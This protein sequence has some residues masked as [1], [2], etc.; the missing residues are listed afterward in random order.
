MKTRILCL[1]EILWNRTDEKHPLSTKQLSDIL[2][3]DYDFP[4][5]HRNTI[6][7]DMVAI[8][9]FGIDV[10]KISSTQNKYYI[11]NRLF[12]L[13]ELKLLIDAVQSSKFITQKKSCELIKKIEKLTS[14]GNIKSIKRNTYNLQ[15]YKP[16]N[17]QI[18]YIVDC[19][20]DAI[21][22]E[23]KI[24]FTYYDYNVKKEKMLK[25]NGEQYV[26]SP[27]YLLWKGD[28]Y[29]LVGY[30]EKRKS[31]T[32]F[33]V[34]RIAVVPDILN[35]K[36]EP[37]PDEFNINKYVNRS[38]KMVDG[39]LTEVTL[40]CTN[41]L[42]KVIIDKFGDNIDTYICDKKTFLLTTEISVSPMF[43][44]WV[45]QFAGDIKIVSPKEVRNEYENMLLKS[46]KQINNHPPVDVGV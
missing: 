9:D 25:N 33:R 5:T 7:K 8:K 36:R 12:E 13:P 40:K 37:L 16:D 34:D 3:K 43:F 15:N 2:E 42:M 11:G 44:G 14:K 29:Y 23:K 26:I 28:F 21:N 17:E 31:V 22:E 45:F 10:I 1:L 19:I 24:S 41:K 38:I 46:L 20:N 27:Y 32:T 30:S 6:T 35:E 4:K 18:Y 39:V